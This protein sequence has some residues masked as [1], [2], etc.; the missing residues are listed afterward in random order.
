MMMKIIFINPPFSKYDGIEGHGGKSIPLNLGYLAS[1]V[2]QQKSDFE[3][4]ILDCEALNLS[5][6]QIRDYVSKFRPD[7]AAITMAT[8]AYEHVVH[9]ADIVKKL[10]PKTSVVVG[11]PHPTALPKETLLEKNL[12]FAVIGEGEFTF[13]ELMET[14]EKNKNDFDKIKGLA[15]KDEKGD[16][17]EN[18]KRELIQNLD[19]LPFPAKDIMPMHAYYLPPSKRISGGAATSIVTSRGCPFNCNFCMAKTI[20][21]RQTRFRSIKNVVDEIEENIEKYQAADFIFQDEFFTINRQRVLEF[22]EE[23]KKRKIKINWFC[24]GR[25]GAV[26]EEMLRA[27][28]SAGCGKIG[29]GFESGDEEMLK[30]M[31]KNNTLAKA[32][33]SARLCKKAG[34]KVVGAFILGYP[35]ET[36]ESAQRT[37]NFAKEINPNTAAFFIAVPYPGTELF[38]L[39]LEKKYI[40]K[41]INWLTFAPL[42]R[43]MPPMDIPNM[44]RKELLA[45]KKKAYRSFYLRPSYILRKLLE[46]RNIDD[47]KSLLSGFAL[48][49]RIT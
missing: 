25:C 4:D 15:Y 49:R 39:A 20:W 48:F 13:L 29:F 1:Y 17:F 46:V 24:Q 44:T 18:E 8:P 7:I 10:N 45:L 47:A 40:K 16:I 35:G 12:D 2:R 37:I 3:I 32:L 22:C 11:G 6:E 26:D 9:V 19:V 42:S 41:P 38:R 43:E 5:Y 34:I 21:G 23:I 33:E 36:K 31:Q 27:I 30:L 28:K 14:L